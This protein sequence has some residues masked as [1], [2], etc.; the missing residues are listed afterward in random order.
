MFEHEVFMQI[1]L[2]FIVAA[3]VVYVFNLI[4]I[5]SVVGLLFS[6]IVMGPSLLSIISDSKAISFLA[7]MGVI[8]LLFMIGLEFSIERL[9]KVKSYV[10]W[11]GIFQLIITSILFTIFMKFAF[12]FQFNVSLFLG[13][14]ASLSSTAL[15]MKF[16][17]ESAQIY[18]PQG[19]ASVGILIFQDIAVVFVI[20]FIPLFTSSDI[21]AS[22]FDFGVTF[23]KTSLI[24]GVLFV[25]AKK[26]VPWILYNFLKLNNREI[27]IV[28]TIA[29]CFLFSLILEKLGFSLALGA[30]MA[31]IVMSESEYSHYVFDNIS[32]FKDVFLSLFFISVGLLIDIDVFF[33]YTHYIILLSLL[34]IFLKTVASYISL[35]IIGTPSV[36]S[37]KSALCINQVG[38]FS[39]VLMSAAF[40]LK[41]VQKDDF[42]IAVSVI[43]V[44][45]IMSS[46]TLKYLDIV[47]DFLFRLLKFQDIPKSPQKSEFK[48]HVI[49]IGFGINGRNLVKSLK[50]FEIPYTVIELNPKTVKTNVASGENIFFGDASGKNTLEQAG[51]SSAKVV[52]IAIS[53]PNATRKIARAVKVFNSNVKVVARGRYYSEVEILKSEGAD[54]VVSEEYEAS[55]EIISVVLD[56]YNIPNSVAYDFLKELR[57]S[58]YKSFR[59]ID[60]H[61]GN[62]ETIKKAAMRSFI[63]TEGSTLV[64]R[65]LSDTNIRSTYNLLVVGIR[66]GNQV[67]ISPG[68]DFVLS[69]S[70][71][72]FLF[73][74]YKKINSYIKEVGQI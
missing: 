29:L 34:V 45:M 61:D 38:E 62:F 73:G 39:F 24:V 28:S 15:V 46:F 37:L 58:G 64:N 36:V 20:M 63:V 59:D 7:E 67:F 55:M 66:R 5:P 25:S 44:T 42:Q 50:F 2:I 19:N 11:G 22:Y 54:F 68:G 4:K 60:F 53:D 17:Q 72:V 65:K 31:G 56:N 70:D 69:P 43:I 8:L 16:L 1:T 57:K 9:N 10:V 27:F 35:K 49:V 48:D 52:V 32:P 13:L 51:I 33:S 6:G 41:L 12:G 23:L 18:S 26:I 21:E 14:T 47:S 71:E 40:S 74:E 3:L 30:F